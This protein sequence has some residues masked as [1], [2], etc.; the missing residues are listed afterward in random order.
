MLMSK[1]WMGAVWSWDHAFNA[2]ALSSGNAELAWDQFMLPMDVQDLT[3]AFPDKWDAGTIAWEFSKPPIHGWALAWM[4]RRGAF[5]DRKHIA[6]VYGPLARWTE[7]YFRY[8]DSDGNGLPEYR[9]GNESG[10]D[11]STVLRDG[12]LIESPYLSAYLVLQM[13]TL[14][15][16]A[17]RLGK[18]KEARRWRNRSSELFR[19]LM[20]RFWNGHAFVSF[21]VA[22]GREIQSKSLLL[23]IPIVLGRR[24]PRDVREQLIQ[25]L[26]QSALTITDFKSD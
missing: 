19:C 3:G 23:C 14:A 2:M 4:M 8:R 15:D 12:G 21:R 5:R 22:D 17:T 24:L 18:P 11:N 25:D 20:Q 10:R 16:L 6:A 9:H 26:K 1:N 13:E 7:F